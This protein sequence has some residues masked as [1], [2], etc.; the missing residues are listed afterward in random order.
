MIE[1]PLLDIVREGLAVAESCTHDGT[2]DTCL[3]CLA[4]Q[5]TRH[6]ITETGPHTHNPR[7]RASED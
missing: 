4:E 7:H 2:D 6:I 1:R 3:D 5:I